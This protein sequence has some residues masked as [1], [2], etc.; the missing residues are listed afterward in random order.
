MHHAMHLDSVQSRSH[1]FCCFNNRDQGVEKLRK[2]LKKTRMTKIVLLDSSR[3][4]QKTTN[5]RAG[6]VG[7]GPVSGQEKS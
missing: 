1:P 5:A 3:R 6:S 4:P 7:S 2:S